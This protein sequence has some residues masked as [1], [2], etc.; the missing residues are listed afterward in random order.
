MVV[1]PVRLTEQAMK[2]AEINLSRLAGMAPRLIVKALSHDCGMALK[3]AR[4]VIRLLV[5]V[6]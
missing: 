4:L 2:P 5:R 6:M 3:L 1:M